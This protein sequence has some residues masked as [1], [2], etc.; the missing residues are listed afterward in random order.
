MDQGWHE[1]PRREDRDPWTPSLPTKEEVITTER[2]FFS[3]NYFQLVRKLP[4]SQN[5]GMM[6]GVNL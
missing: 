5:F 3:C 2:W 4:Q 6:V 1:D